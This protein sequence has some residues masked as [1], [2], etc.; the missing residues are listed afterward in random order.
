MP[1]RKDKVTAQAAH[2]LDV[3]RALKARFALLE[4]LL[5]DQDLI[6]RL[7]TGRR[8]HGLHILRSALVES[9]IL[10]MV[11]IVHDGDARSPSVSGLITALDDDVLRAELREDYAVW[12]VAPDDIDD[13]DLRALVLS[14]E[15]RDKAARRTQFDG[16]VVKLHDRAKHFDAT[17]PIEA[18]RRMQDQLI[19]HNQISFNGTNYQPLDVARLELKLSDIGA[20]IGAL[21]SIMDAITLIFRNSSFDFTHLQEQLIADRNG[22]WASSP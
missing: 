1:T 18:V 17:T 7:R 16:L 3:Y 19:A 14:S 4:P 12:N 5:V 2:L 9:C 11:K 10:G 20:I 13:P 22:F 15:K 8:R 21:E 6:T